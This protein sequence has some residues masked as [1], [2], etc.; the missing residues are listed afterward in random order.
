LDERQKLYETKDPQECVKIDMQADPDSFLCDQFD[1][2]D[3]V[4]IVSD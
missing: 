2:E 4:V 1:I 3:V